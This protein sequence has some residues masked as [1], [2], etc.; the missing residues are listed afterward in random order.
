MSDDD[1][2]NIVRLRYTNVQNFFPTGELETET[3]ETDSNL[4]YFFCPSGQQYLEASECRMKVNGVWVENSFAVNGNVEDGNSFNTMAL[5]PRFFNGNSLQQQVAAYQ[6]S[7]STGALDSF[8]TPTTPGAFLIPTYYR[9][10]SNCAHRRS[11]C[12]MAH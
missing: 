4:L 1:L 10:E 9:H 7:K 5:C 6:Q 8:D 11:T 2:S 12:E 3:T